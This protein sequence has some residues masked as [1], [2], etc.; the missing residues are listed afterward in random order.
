MTDVADEN[1]LETDLAEAARHEAGHVRVAQLEGA[2]VLWARSK[3]AGSGTTK[4]DEQ[5]ELPAL[6]R[7]RIAV[8][9]AVAEQVLGDGGE[10]PLPP[11]D[12]ELLRRALRD[13]NEAEVTESTVRADV[14]DELSS[15]RV[16]VEAL[17]AALEA[18]AN[19]NVPG[20]DLLAVVE[21]AH[22]SPG[23]SQLDGDL[24]ALGTQTE[25]TALESPGDGLR[26]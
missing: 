10:V 3:R 2:T 11:N 15:R 18:R 12:R 16:E 23:Q 24:G 5:D 26:D 21:R 6:T 19:A 22:L 7:A 4:V 13:L 14:R 1:D 17:Q 8:A 25:A 20:A 9:G